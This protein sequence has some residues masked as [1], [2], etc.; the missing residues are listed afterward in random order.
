MIKQKIFIIFLV[1]MVLVNPVVFAQA[2]TVDSSNAAGNNLLLSYVLKI[3]SDKKNG[4]AES[5]NGAIKTIFLKEGKARSR[6]V[7]L[8]R[9]QSIY[10][11][12]G[13]K[14]KITV[15]KESGSD[16]YKRNLSVE[17]WKKMN[18]KYV[19]AGYE[20]VNDSISVMNY[21]C[22]KVIIHLKDGKRIIA[23]Y[24]TDLQNELFKKMEPAFA[25]VPGVVLQYEYEN[26]D[27]KFI[28]TANDISFA[29]TS[30]EVYKIP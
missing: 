4:I 16:S 7:S 30:A 15:L 14:E 10:Y 21:N 8:M 19:D 9:I 2:E 24:T 5:Y 12:G 25:P 26:K 13:A 3:E 17:D 23:F 6:M 29:V 11:S 18:N 1:S 20:F 28:Y 27:A 22:K